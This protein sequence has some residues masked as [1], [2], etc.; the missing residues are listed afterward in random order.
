MS[1]DIRAFRQALGQF[2]TGVAVVTMAEDGKHPI[3]TGAFVL[4]QFDQV[5]EVNHHDVV[6]LEHLT[7]GRYVEEEDE[8]FTYLRAFDRL[9][10]IALDEDSSRE[11]IST[12]R[13][14]WVDQPAM[15]VP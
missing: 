13:N 3:G 4:L 15:A 7:G 6:Y 2:P 8:T 11:L 12:A 1:F 14:K 5:H 10:E 9:S